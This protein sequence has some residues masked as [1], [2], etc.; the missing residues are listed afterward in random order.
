MLE[1]TEGGHSQL[2]G[3]SS[4]SY[5]T[6]R[7]KN[8][9]SCTVLEFPSSLAS[10]ILLHLHVKTSQDVLKESKPTAWHDFTQSRDGSL[11][12]TGFLLSQL[13]SNCYWPLVYR[14]SGGDTRD[15]NL[16]ISKGWY[17]NNLLRFLR[18]LMPGVWLKITAHQLICPLLVGEHQNQTASVNPDFLWG[19][20]TKWACTV[21][22][23]WC[24]A[25]LISVLMW[26]V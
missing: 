9:K 7:K 25:L 3:L 13:D 1:H 14:V 17:K 12:L 23:C 26:W 11:R 10:S 15:M 8:L 22:L 16:S 24:W 19:P 20:V 21:R 2:T 4:T 6:W 5:P 18:R